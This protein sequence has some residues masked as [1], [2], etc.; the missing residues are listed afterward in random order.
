M[1][2]VTIVG[3]LLRASEA[4]T[5]VVPAESIKAGRLPDDVALPAILLRTVSSLEWQ[6]L[7]RGATV[8]TTDR[9]AVAVRAKSYRDQRAVIRLIVAACAGQT[10]SI[11]GFESVAVL[12]AGT[13]PDGIGP[14]DSYEQTQD[15]RVSFDAPA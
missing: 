8:P 15:F 11:A 14:G 2:G 4:L 6:A 9:V 13:G 1:S 12:T 7:T 3:A 5:A 10:G